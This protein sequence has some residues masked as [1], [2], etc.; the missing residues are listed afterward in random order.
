MEIVEAAAEGNDELLMKYLEGET[1]SEDEILS[2]LKNA[3]KA[4]SFVPVLVSS[5][6]AGVGMASL[7]NSIINL[8]PAPDEIDPV[9]A[10][11]A[12]GEQRC[13]RWQERY[14]RVY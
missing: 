6:T 2:G 5:G 13:L 11:G 8:M 14:L 1:L 10:E 4:R 3:V 7:L 12:K 9:I